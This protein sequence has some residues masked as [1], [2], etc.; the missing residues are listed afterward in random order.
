MLASETARRTSFT[1]MRGI[2]S[3]AD[4]TLPCG[5]RDRLA[6]VPAGLRTAFGSGGHTEWLEQWH[7]ACGRKRGPEG[8][9]A[10]RRPE[11][12]AKWGT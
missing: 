6:H 5:D 2:V 1:F 9:V 11:R 3:Y 4:E 7:R 12:A 10:K 8:T